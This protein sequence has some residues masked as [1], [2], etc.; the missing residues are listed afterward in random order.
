VKANR[1]DDSVVARLWRGDFP[2]NS[3]TSPDGDL[4]YVLAAGRL[5]HQR[6]SPHSRSNFDGA[7][8]QV[9]PFSSPNLAKLLVFYSSNMTE[10]RREL[11]RF[12]GWV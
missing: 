3:L 5:A 2:R 8:S 4:V 6:L 7:N 11:L 12:K 1:I 10:N 9:L